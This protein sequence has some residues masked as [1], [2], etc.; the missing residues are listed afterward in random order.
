[1]GRIKGIPVKLHVRQK[2]GEDPFGAPIYQE[3]IVT[4]ENVL[5]ALISSEDMTMQL[6][7]NGNMSK[8]KLAIPKGD[9]HEWSNTIVEFFGQKFRTVG[10]P[11]QGIEPML[12]L[13]WN[14]Q[15]EVEC[16]E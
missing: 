15:I 10:S 6:N 16:Y 1:M 8:Y 4:V 14:K 11:V 9:N 13:A 12:P 3:D 5:I 7:V 2:I